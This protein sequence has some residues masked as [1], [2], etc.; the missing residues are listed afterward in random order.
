EQGTPEVFQRDSS[1]Y[2]SQ[3]F[4]PAD[5]GPTG[6]TSVM[7][8]S[9]PG[10]LVECRPIRWIPGSDLL[11]VTPI[12]R[13]SFDHVGPAQAFPPITRARNLDAARS[14]LN[15]NSASA[16]IPVNLVHYAGEYLFIYPS[17]FASAIKPL[18]NQK[19]WHGFTVAT[20]TTESL[21]SVTCATVRAAI[22]S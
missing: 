2:A 20:R 9:I 1:L 18:V 8:G 12:S 19:K 11:F 10:A 22:Q 17:A 4:Y 15:W 3:S 16:S 7:F 5:M 13:W 6:P 21:G 14:F